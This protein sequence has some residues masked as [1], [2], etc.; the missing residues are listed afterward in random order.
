MAYTIRTI[1]YTGDKGT[2]LTMDVYEASNMTRGPASGRIWRECP[3]CALDYPE[4][5]MVRIGGKWYCIPNGCYR[6]TDHRWQ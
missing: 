5:N 4:Q 3:V 6:D 2:A 1:A